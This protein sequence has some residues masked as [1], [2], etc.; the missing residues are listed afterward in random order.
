MQSHITIIDYGINNI[1]SIQRA[2]S[3]IGHDAKLAANPDEIKNA[4]KLILPGV[5]SFENG[6]KNL[7]N[8]DGMIEA[9]YEFVKSG[10]L[11]IAICLGMQMLLDSSEENGLHKGLGIISGSVK[12]IPIKKENGGL[13]K[14]PHVQWNK[15]KAVPDLQ[16]WENTYLKNV[17]HDDYFYF[18][19][20]YV[21]IPKD[22]KFLI[23]TSEYEGIDLPA[24][25][26]KEN[27]TAFQFHPEKSG[28]SGLIILENFVNT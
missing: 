13:R 4:E 21:S 27:I 18:V 14:I 3:E 10:K 11:V 26:N 24:V 19:H 22:K 12:K 5:G 25:I 20:S 9:I 6:M 28:Q 2:I 1:K 15:L 16:R 7:S 17:K 23:A 8:V